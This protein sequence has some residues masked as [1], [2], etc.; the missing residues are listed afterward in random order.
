MK[1]LMIHD[2]YLIR[3]GEDESTDV[4]I[5]MLRQHGN[6]VDFLEMDNRIIAGQSLLRTGVETIWSSRAYRAVRERI[7]SSQCDLVHVQN[8]FPLFSPSIHHAAKAE[9]KP[10]VQALRNYRLFCLNVVFLRDH[11]I[12][13][14]CMGK[15]LPWPGVIH[16]CYRGSLAGS[17]SVASMLVIHRALNTWKSKVDVFVALT[18]FARRKYVQGGLAEDHIMVKPNF[19]LSDPG[20]G[21]HQGNFVLFA[22]RLSPEKG[23]G[24]ISRAWEELK[25][26][27]L[28]IVGDGPMLAELVELSRR[29]PNIELHGRL[30][31]S[32][33]LELM[34]DARLLIFPSEWYEGFPRVIVEAFA[35]G[36]PVLTTNLGS[37]SEIVVENISG[38]HMHKADS[39]E[40]ARKVRWG[41]EHQGQLAEMGRNARREYLEKYTSDRNYQVLMNIYQAAVDRSARQDT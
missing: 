30:D 15:I 5:S 12:C 22:G 13:E 33:V 9:G 28:K 17:T 27:P 31:H 41:W 39:F 37:M 32:T 16:R 40:L 6:T 25:D 11:R 35:C 14:D 21:Y 23:L 36:L 18:E 19:T 34:K 1:I 7:S 38:L 10:V 2:R 29:N 3:G 20:L 26:V 8:F 4:E 24:L